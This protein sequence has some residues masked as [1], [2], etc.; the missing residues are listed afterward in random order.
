M[1]YTL[2]WVEK[3]RP[4]DLNNIIL[5]KNN[6]TILHNIIKCNHFPNLLLYGPPGT[7][8]TT[9]IIRLIELW[10]KNNNQVNKSLCVHL[11][12]SDERGIDIVRNHIT[13]FIKMDGLFIKGTKFII[14]DEVD[15]M[16]KNAQIA[17][18]YLLQNENNV[19]FC[20]ICNYISKIDNCLQRYFVKL[21]FNSLSKQNINTL[22]K[23][24][25]KREN[26]EINDNII[27]H[28]QNEFNTDIRSAINYIQ[29]NYSILN[30]K[31]IITDDVFLKV[32]ELLKNSNISVN[33]IIKTLIN[34]ITEY[35]I[36]YAKFI[37]LYCKYLL[38]NNN[39]THD[40]LKVIENVT[41]NNLDYN[42]IIPY[43]VVQFRFVLL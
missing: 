35:N 21:K 30:N 40:L 16:T 27:E 22:L 26:L 37:D 15:Y 32:T 10:Q 33:N 41:N 38:N 9:T 25:I 12:A 19:R 36:T 20:L 11:N 1:L 3:Y 8:K 6:E 17:L 29:C 28:I 24:I 7:G 42:Y 2:P 23:T 18:K 34:K 5:S 4:I 43:F 14:L 31:A 39:I 13:Q